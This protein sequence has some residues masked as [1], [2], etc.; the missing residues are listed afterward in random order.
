MIT[1]PTGL[2]ILFW[3]CLAAALDRFGPALSRATGWRWL[4]GRYRILIGS[5]LVWAATLVVGGAIVVLL[6]ALDL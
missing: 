2:V 1:L 4:A 6:Y 5:G 3:G